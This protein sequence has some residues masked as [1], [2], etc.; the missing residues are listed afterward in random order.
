LKLSYKI[1]KLDLAVN[2]AISRNSS[3]FKENI[4]IKIE[5][6]EYVGAGEV[7]PNIRYSETI[8]RI[9]KELSPCLELSSIKELE[10]YCLESELCH[11]LKC[12]I[13][14]AIISIKSQ[15]SS[16][17]ISQYLSLKPIEG[18]T[19]FSIPIMEEEL[20][21]DY[22]KTHGHYESYKIKVNADNAVSF[23]TK[24]ALLTDKGLRIDANEAFL[25]CE[26]FLVFYNLVKHLNI[27]FIEQ[28]MPAS[29]FTEYVKL[30]PFME[31]DL[32]ADESVEDIANFSE[33]KN[34]FHGINIKL[35]KTGGIQN[36]LSLI[37]DAQKVDLKIMVG[38]MIESSLGISYAL[39][40][41][42][43]AEYLD[44]DGALLLKEDPYKELISYKKNKLNLN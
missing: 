42:E 30:K 4:F 11:S 12:G 13:E 27:E 38:C 8:E 33:L 15:Q 1:K 24:I 43:Y 37:K 16:Q 10:A 41:S 7:A 9:K 32:I 36:A 44:L 17:S 31:H 25:S 14:Q 22:L 21:E 23:V 19:S 29:L 5:D 18:L 2:W 40:L 26:Q 39:N 35:M 3:L 28:P 34:G 6:G 20:L